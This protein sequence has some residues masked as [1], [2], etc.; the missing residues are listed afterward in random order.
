M[1]ADLPGKEDLEMSLS[2]AIFP[3]EYDEDYS[4]LTFYHGT[5]DKF[6]LVDL[7]P[8]DETGVIREFDREEFR[9]KVFFTTHLKSAINYAKKASERFGGKPI[10]YRVAPVGEIW[11]VRDDEFVADSAIIEEGVWYFD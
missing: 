11:N 3:L 10:V 7:R 5:S 9:D 1:A 6:S 2:K 8:P 4:D